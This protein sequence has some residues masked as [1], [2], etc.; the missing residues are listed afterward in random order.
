[1][2][3]PGRLRGW[4]TALLLLLAAA[5]AGYLATLL[6]IPA[7]LPG[8]VAVV[9]SLR[10]LAQVEATDRLDSLGL[11]VRLGEEIPDHNVASGLV[12]WQSPAPGTQLPPGALVQIGLSSGNPILMVPD[13]SGVNATQALRIL[14][15][16]GFHSGAVDS[17]DAPDYPGTVMSSSP[18]SGSSLR[19]GG[20]VDLLVS[21]GPQPVEV[22]YLI[23][24]PVG[25]AR[26]LLGAAGLEVGEF[27]QLIGSNPGVVLGQQPPAGAAIPRGA[28]VN[29]TVGGEN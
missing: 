18:P 15:A 4:L 11:R 8:T 9:P 1:M 23:G 17:T 13:L 28:K 19:A 26:Q 24:L 14:N 10:G 22:P 20:T 2:S 29:L 12:A 5:G 21:R 7:P 25:R 6:V 16:A 27:E 3:G